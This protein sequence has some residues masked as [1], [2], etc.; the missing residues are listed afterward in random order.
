MTLEENAI[1][2]GAGSAV[3]EYLA[4]SAIVLPVMNFGL[5]DGLIEH[6]KRE[7]LLDMLGL[8]PTKMLA[9]ISDRLRLLKTATQAAL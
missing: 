5:P 6:G 2:G 7:Q 8:T 9:S 3:N 1:M 4:Q